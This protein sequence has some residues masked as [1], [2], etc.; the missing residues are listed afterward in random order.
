MQKYEGGSD[1]SAFSDLTQNGETRTELHSFTGIIVPSSQKK[2]F[3]TVNNYISSF[4]LWEC[5]KGQ[6][7]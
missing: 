3:P 7:L 6:N 1:S 5:E 4:L 2:P